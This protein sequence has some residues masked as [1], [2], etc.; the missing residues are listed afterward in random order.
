MKGTRHANPGTTPGA[1]NRGWTSTAAEVADARVP[2]GTELRLAEQFEATLGA[3]PETDGVERTLLLGGLAQ[4]LYNGSDDDPRGLSLSV[5]AVAMARRIADPHLLMRALNARAL[6]VPQATHLAEL[7][8]IAEELH[9]LAARTRTPG[10]ELLAHMMDTHHRL[11]LHDLAGADLAAARCAAL[12]DDLRLPWPRLQ[13]TM[14][15][16]NRLTWP[17]SGRSTTSWPCWRPRW[18][19]AVRSISRRG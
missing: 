8:E 18:N 7:M 6:S 9:V 12:L 19:A 4:E 16:A 13:H 17:A 5:E 1:S 15:R 14:W 2:P 3:L 10:L 11:E